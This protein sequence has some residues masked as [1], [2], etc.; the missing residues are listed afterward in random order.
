VQ[1]DLTQADGHAERKAAL[2]M[3][4]RHSPGS[5]RRL[6]LGADKGYDPGRLRP[7]GCARRKSL[8]RGR[9]VPCGLY[10]PQMRRRGRR[11]KIPLTCRNVRVL[12]GPSMAS[13]II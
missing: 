10:P 1:G 4:H 6:T 5:T 2:N 9:P 8:H 7:C 11:S 12:A 13:V 3:V